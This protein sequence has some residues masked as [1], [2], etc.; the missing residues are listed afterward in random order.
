MLD[1]ASPLA[2]SI[3]SA[4]KP[5]SVPQPADVCDMSGV[6]PIADIGADI[7]FGHEVA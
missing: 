5:R 7:D 1:G 2:A 6:A 3:Y 4:R